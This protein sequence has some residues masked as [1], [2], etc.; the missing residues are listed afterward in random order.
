MGWYKGFLKEGALAAI[1]QYINGVWS[2]AGVPIP[3]TLPYAWADFIL[4]DYVNF[5]IIDF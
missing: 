4:L 2:V 3:A 1:G 5:L